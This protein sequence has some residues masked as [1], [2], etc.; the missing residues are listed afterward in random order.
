MIKQ[1]RND[2]C[3]CNSGLKYK[4]CC[5]FT[6]LSTI[7]NTSQPQSSDTIQNCL[8]VLQLKFNKHIFIDIT[9]NLNNDTYITY[10]TKNFTSNI[11]MIAEK[12]I[13]NIIVFAPRIETDQ[14]DIMLL[15]HGGY[16]TF[17]K[18]NLQEI[19]E[20]LENFIK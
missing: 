20:S 19:L 8:S 4:N 7:Y 14:S 9:D 10:Q 18:E 13:N 2:K 17:H 16:K 12:T 15:Y 1:G 6:R 5:L 11:V 3:N